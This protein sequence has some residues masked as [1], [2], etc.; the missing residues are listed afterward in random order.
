MGKDYEWWMEIW[1][2][3]VIARHRLRTAGKVYSQDIYQHS[4]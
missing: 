4:Q 1:K 2:E 3:A